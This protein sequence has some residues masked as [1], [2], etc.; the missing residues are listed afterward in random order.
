MIV[1]LKH[2]RK[3]VIWARNGD[4]GLDEDLHAFLDVFSSEVIEGN[5]TL[6]IGIESECL[7]DNQWV[8]AGDGHVLGEWDSAFSIAD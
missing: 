1:S 5:F 3:E 2:L 4:L 8:V 6:D 7:G